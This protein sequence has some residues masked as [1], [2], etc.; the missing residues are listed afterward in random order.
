MNI[1]HSKPQLTKEVCKEYYQRAQLLPGDGQDIGPRRE[2]RLELQTKYEIPEI[3]ATNILNGLYIKEYV[4]I[5]EEAN[6]E[7]EEKKKEE[8]EKKKKEA[9]KEKKKKKQDFG[10]PDEE[11][12]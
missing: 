1:D 9:I 11:D 12:F 7:E 5:Y 10:I 4:S 8:E 2:L 6:K 3:W